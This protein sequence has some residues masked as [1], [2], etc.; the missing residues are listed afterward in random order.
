[1]LFEVQIYSALSV[2]YCIQ[3]RFNSKSYS[4]EN[5]R[6]EVTI[7]YLLAYDPC[8]WLIPK[9][10]AE[11]LKAVSGEQIRQ[12]ELSHYKTGPCH[13]YMTKKW[14]AIEPFYTT[15]LALSV[16]YHP[17][18]NLMCCFPVSF[19]VLWYM[20]KEYILALPDSVF[21]GSDL[22]LIRHITSKQQDRLQGAAKPP[23]RHQSYSNV[24]K[25]QAQTP[26]VTVGRVPWPKENIL[27]KWSGECLQA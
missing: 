24:I 26:R 23:H 22:G 6:P 8:L 15:E 1:M 27:G 9:H 5:P 21:S 17:S 13:L 10:K 3:S 18:S 20:K 12:E 7:R 4:K 16:F 11:G 2:F 25:C 14:N 19:S